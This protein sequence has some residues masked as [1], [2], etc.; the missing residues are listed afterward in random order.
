MGPG[1][2]ELFMEQEASLR[3]GMQDDRSDRHSSAE[4]GWVPP[5]KGYADKFEDLNPKAGED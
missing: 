5:P 4:R 3:E 2:R 1:Y